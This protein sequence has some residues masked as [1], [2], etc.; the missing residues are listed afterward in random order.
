MTMKGFIEYAKEQPLAR[1]FG[2]SSILIAGTM[3]A[4]RQS[5]QAAISFA[6][7]GVLT[8]CIQR[9][10]TNTSWAM[11]KVGPKNN[12][13]LSKLRES[14]E[15]NKLNAFA[16]L[17]SATTVYVLPVVSQIMLQNNYSK[18]VAALATAI[19]LTSTS[20]LA[21]NLLLD[22]ETIKSTTIYSC[23]SL[24][25]NF[26]RLSFT[27][28]YGDQYRSVGAAIGSIVV[29]GFA[30][31]AS[32][33][34]SSFDLRNRLFFALECALIHGTQRFLSATADASLSNT[35]LFNATS[36]ILTNTAYRLLREELSKMLSPKTEQGRNS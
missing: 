1:L 36:I 20:N 5:N 19:T 22:G 32:D 33:K 8:M 21:L 9:Y 27:A 15:I 13:E 3:L 24:I 7:V 23:I 34:N 35:L 14:Y 30:W 12:H 6:L 17:Y 31:M 10:L 11:Y 16:L 25:S 28:H 29:S 2:V 18:P 26:S 4:K